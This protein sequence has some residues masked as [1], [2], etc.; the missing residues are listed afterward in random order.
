LPRAGSVVTVA[1]K[2]NE[3]FSRSLNGTPIDTTSKEM[4][5][6]VA[7][8][9]W[10]GMN[11]KKSEKLTGSGGIKAPRFID[12][13]ADPEKGKLVYDQLC[14]RCHG[15]DGQGQFVVDVLK[16][17]TKQQ[18]GNATTDDLYYYPPLWGSHSFNAVATLYRLSKLAGFI[19]NNMPYPITYSSPVLT[20]E[21]AWDVA[22]YVNSSERPV[23]DYSKDYISDISKKPYDFPFPPYADK[24]TEAQHKF[25][26]YKEMPSANKAH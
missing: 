8:V 16:D 19:Q 6:Y 22:A 14:S 25:G 3:C 10:L 21:Q 24:F 7:Y 17:E 12:R 13:A 5:A 9:K 23:K 11:F 2:I 4:L 18:G 1:Q 26:P 20:D 15:K